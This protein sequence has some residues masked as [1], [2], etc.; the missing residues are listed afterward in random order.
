MNSWILRQLRALLL[1]DLKGHIPKNYFNQ[2]IIGLQ[3]NSSFKSHEYLS[4]ES[5]WGYLAAKL[6]QKLH[7]Q[8]PTDLTPR[9][10]AASETLM[11]LGM[12]ASSE[13]A[14]S[15]CEQIQNKALEMK[16][17]DGNAGNV[18]AQL[19]NEAIPTF[20]NNIRG[21]LQQYLH[22]LTAEEARPYVSLVTG[23]SKE[24]TKKISARQI[25]VEDIVEIKPNFMGIGLNLNALW[26]KLFNE[27]T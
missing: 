9:Q 21:A 19:K 18:A 16:I 11:S 20:Q 2:K 3:L 26:R 6:G 1:S 10:V 14:L 7:F 25:P 27:Q 12:L 22:H 13:A 23:D 15:A 8:P 5:Q 4:F 17:A 24:E